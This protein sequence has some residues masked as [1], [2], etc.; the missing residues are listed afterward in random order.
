MLPR[1]LDTADMFDPKSLL[2][3]LPALPG[4]YRM[5]NEKGDV[6]YVGK[7]LNLK[8][9]VSSYFQKTDISPRIRLMLRQ[10]AM[11]E[12]TVVRSEGEA[13]LLENNLIKALSPKYNILFRDDKSYPYLMLSGHTYPRLAFYRGALARQ[14]HYFGPFPNSDAVRES[15]HIL[16]RVFK[17]RTCED[18]V[19]NNRS[20]PC[21]LHQIKRC[22]APCVGVIDQVAYADDVRHASDF[23]SGKHGTLLDELTRAMQHASES[24]DFEQAAELRDQIQALAR[25]QAR[26]YVSSNASDI[27]CDVVSAVLEGGIACINLVMV[28]GGRHLGDKTFFP[29]H[30]EDYDAPSV[31]QAFLLQHYVGQSLPP[32]VFLSHAVEPILTEVLSEQAGHKLILN[33]NPNGERRVWLEMSCKNAQLA[34]AQ[35]QS[36]TMHQAA[37]LQA[38]REVLGDENIVRLECFDISHTQGEATVA[39]CVVYDKGTM[40]PGEYRHFNIRGIT[41]GDDY[42]AMRD[43][44]TRRYNAL[45]AGDGVLPDVLLIDGGRGQV[46][47][48]VEVLDELGLGALPIVGVAKGEGRKPGLETLILVRQ[49]K[50]LQLAADHPALHLIQTVRDEAHRFAISRHRARRAKARTVSTLEQIPGIGPKRRQRLLT[51]FGG[52]KGLIAASADDIAQVGGISHALAD[53]IYRALH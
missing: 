47:V 48:A 4:V 11:I 35:R 51:R 19:F 27:D 12:T 24:L 21:L 8:K 50:T 10:V 6:L 38:L 5:L 25:V 33:S 15:I 23:L 49:Q 45:V 29:E 20:R 52:L 34:I 26:Q 1:N 16:Q 22:S 44:L 14:H 13:L 30:A 31:L 9:R 41:P 39:S 7:A 3:S 40:Q 18:S 28:R 17:L 37:R 32:V 46:A 42:A 36:S 2:D 53:I 43:A